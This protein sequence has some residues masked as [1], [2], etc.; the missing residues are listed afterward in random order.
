MYKKARPSTHTQ[1]LRKAVM[2]YDRAKAKV[3]AL[4]YK[5]KPKT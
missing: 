3:K 1:K 5:N 2:L 4:K